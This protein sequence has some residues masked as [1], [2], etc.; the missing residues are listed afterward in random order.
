MTLPD[1]I[2]QTIAASHSAIEETPAAKGMIAGTIDRE[3]YARL[4]AQLKFIH[5]TLENQL[6][7]KPELAGLYDPAEMKRSHVITRDL[8]NLDFEADDSVLD[9]TS[10]LMLL[11]RQWGEVAPWMLIGPLYVLEGSRMG[12]MALVRPVA[13]ALGL[14]VRPNVGVDYHLDGMA[15]RPQV[16]MQ[17]KAKLAATPFSDAQK[18]NICRA[19]AATMTALHSL[20]SAKCPA[21]A[22]V[23]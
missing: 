5:D 6:H 12:S 18:E 9:P 8:E 13:R 4:L 10:H 17:F 21:A 3:A 11:F 19:A 20:Y 7:G 1:M 14:E 23:A 2:R 15:T 16:W 22:V